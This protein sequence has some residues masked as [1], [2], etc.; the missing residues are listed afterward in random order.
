[1]TERPNL[2]AAHGSAS[3]RGT[4]ATAH[5]GSRFHETDTRNDEDK[6]NEERPEAEG[7][8]VVADLSEEVVW[9]VRVRWPEARQARIP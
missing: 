2:R 1:M 3:I 8:R 9:A 4:D 7:E 6:G 5:P